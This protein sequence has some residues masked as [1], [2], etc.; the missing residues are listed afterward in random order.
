MAAPRPLRKDG[1]VS[2][3]EG[4]PAPGG[5]SIVVRIWTDPRLEGFR[6]R[7]TCVP[8]VAV[9]HEE[10]RVVDSPDAVAETVR[11]CLEKIVGR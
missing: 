2:P 9:D 3:L 4:D 8:D 10:V 5:A 6:A 11:Q 1:E 7:V